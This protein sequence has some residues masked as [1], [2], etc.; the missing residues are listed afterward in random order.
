MVESIADA[1]EKKFVEAASKLKMGEPLDRATQIGPMARGDLRE[2]LEQQVQA[3][4]KM[5]ARVVLMS[6]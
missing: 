3:S 2:A 4:L 6:L 5:R 1:F